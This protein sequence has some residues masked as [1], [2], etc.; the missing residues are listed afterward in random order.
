MVCYVV[1]YRMGTFESRQN[2][3]DL[4]LLQKLFSGNIDC[5]ELLTSIKLKN[6][7]IV[8]IKSPQTF[9]S[10]SIFKI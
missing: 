10:Q 1:I 8:K 3:M 4:C 9:F 7:I 6:T 2:M 5:P